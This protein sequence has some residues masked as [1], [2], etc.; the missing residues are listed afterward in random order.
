MNEKIGPLNPNEMGNISEIMDSS[1]FEECKEIVDKIEKFVINILT[2]H[3]NLVIRIA[4]NLQKNETIT[5]KEI[6]HILPKKLE[7]SLEVNN[8]L[9]R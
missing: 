1:I 2:K 3:K 5:Y 7:D 8:I 9:K 6:K 4:N